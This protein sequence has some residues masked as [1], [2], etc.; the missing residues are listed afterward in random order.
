MIEVCISMVILALILMNV[1]MVMRASTNAYKAGVVI[2]SLESQADQTMHRIAMA[3][4]SSSSQEITPSTEAPLFTPRIDYTINLGMEDGELIWSDPE[5]IEL[6]QATGQIVWSQNP[7]DPEVRSV[8]WSNWAS[9]FLEGEIPNGEDDN[10][11][12]IT[13]EEGLS[14]TKE[15]DMVTILLTL[16]RTDGEGVHYLKTLERHATCRN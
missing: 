12:E 5:R 9:G 3:V 8:V 15:G 7:E 13:D 1:H 6:Q 4:M 10:N 16:E 2:S 14:F 11:N